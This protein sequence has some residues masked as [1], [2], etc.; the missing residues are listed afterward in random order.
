[1]AQQK[2]L[3][4]N[5][6][7]YGHLFY[8]CKKPITSFGIVCYRITETNMIEYLL[9]QRKD[10]LGYVDFLR[11]KY[12][13]NNNFQL[14]N[15]INEMTETEK[16]NILTMTYTALWDKLW[17]KIN[18]R[19]DIKNEDKFNFIK[20]YFNHL[21]ETYN[22]IK[23][24]Q[25]KCDLFRYCLLYKYGGIYLD[26]DLEMKQSFDNII[27]NNNC[28][29]LIS[30]IGAHTSDKNNVYEVCNGYIITTPNNPIFLELINLIIKNPNPTD[31]G[32][33]V[34][35]FYSS[36][37]SDTLL[38][39]YQYFEKNNILYMLQ[40]EV[41]INNRYFVLDNKNQ[42]VFNSNGNLYI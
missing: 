7:T 22:I 35:N 24:P 25:H 39:P 2:F 27:I 19:Y 3:C 21:L 23:L 9:V 26:V 32:L 31:Y 8:N 10:S 15:I 12:N 20:T 18:D 30:S 40:K 42:V 41:N 11:G 33:N 16:H 5:C 37:K 17:N 4:N 14:K 1:M 38:K 13:E 28:A 36:L 6:G 29:D 34:K